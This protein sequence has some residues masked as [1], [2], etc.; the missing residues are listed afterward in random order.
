MNTFEV[1]M[2]RFKSSLFWVHVPSWKSRVEYWWEHSHTSVPDSWKRTPARF[3]GKNSPNLG[4][5][6]PL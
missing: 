5:D 2:L 3:L 4:M 1:V 6:L